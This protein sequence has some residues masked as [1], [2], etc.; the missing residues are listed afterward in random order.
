MCVQCAQGKNQFSIYAQVFLYKLKYKLNSSI[1]IIDF[2][3]GLPGQLG[4]WARLCSPVR[5]I[6]QKCAFFCKNR[7]KKQPMVVHRLLC[8]ALFRPWALGPVP[9]L[10]YGHW[11]NYTGSVICSVLGWASCSF[12]AFFSPNAACISSSV[13]LSPNSS[14]ISSSVICSG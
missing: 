12:G 13:I 4:A 11:T 8:R 9:A 6:R 5:K 3:C 2:S 14:R 7:I 10:P 1:Y